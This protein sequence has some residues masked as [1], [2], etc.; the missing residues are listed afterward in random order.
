[1][2]DAERFGFI[3]QEMLEHWNNSDGFIDRDFEA[4]H[5]QF[6]TL[7]ERLRQ[8]GRPVA[9]TVLLRS[10]RGRSAASTVLER[11]ERVRPASSTAFVRNVR[12]RPVAEDEPALLEDEPAAAAAAA[13]WDRPAAAAEWDRPAAAAEWDR[14][15]AAAAGDVRRARLA[16]P[17]EQ[18][19][20]HQM[21]GD[22]ED[23]QRGRR[24]IGEGM[25]GASILF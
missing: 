12:G 6:A 16:N 13:E 11:N 2:S 1:M 7:Y 17:G 21:E 15:A 24:R 4:L 9:S 25:G 20:G 8:R 18:F 3:L 23:Q 19:R 22:R 10:V 14:P 5:N